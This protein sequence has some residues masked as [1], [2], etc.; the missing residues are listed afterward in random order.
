MYPQKIK[1]LLNNPEIAEILGA[2]IG[3]G[4]IESKGTG[5]YITGSPTEDKEYYDN[6]LALLFE[7]I[8]QGKKPDIRFG[9]K[10]AI[11]PLILQ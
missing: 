8:T 2:F 5:L 3:D 11:Y 1:D 7:Q 9:K 4:W 10:W 6:F